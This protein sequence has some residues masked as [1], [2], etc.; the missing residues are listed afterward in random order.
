MFCD[1]LTVIIKKRDMEET[2]NAISEAFASVG[3][4]V[5]QSKTDFYGLNQ[6]RTQPFVLLGADLACT[7][8]FSQKQLQKQQ[9]YF[10][11]LDRIPMHPQLKTTLLR[12]CGAPRLR[13]ILSAM[14]PAWSSPLA[15]FFDKATIQALSKIIHVGVE[16]LQDSGLL[17]DAMGASIPQYSKL[18]GKLYEAARNFAIFDVHTPVELVTK[19]DN[20]QQPTA[21]HNLDSQWLW[22]DGT[23]S[24]AEFCTAYCIRL[25]IIQP[26][27]RVQPTRCDCGKLIQNDT[28]QLH[29]TI[30][31][32]Q[33]TSATHTRRHN[34]LRD[35]ICRICMSF[36]I[37]AVKEPTCYQ[38]EVGRKRPDIL[39]LTH[40]IL[41]TD[42]T[43]VKP[44]DEPGEAAKAADE[45]KRKQ[46]RSAVE[47]KQHVFIPGACEAYGLIGEGLVKLVKELAKDLPLSSQFVFKRT[48]MSAISTALAR[49]R[50]QGIYGT[51]HL[52][53]RI[54][55]PH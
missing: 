6:V 34:M 1:D 42:V 14:P 8:E 22:Y 24:P 5:N 7:G 18:N 44:R 50:A 12:V 15:E 45:E 2:L 10:A 51:R 38:Y 19:G 23:M 26:E 4:R 49:S 55:F 32:D 35:E 20:S 28:E 16:E 33:F 37:S 3:L 54:I 53:D 29:H 40:R 48:M 36:G 13:Y 17:H 41:V 52:Q 47:S 39:F 46:H 27:N 31:C 43:I 11:L 9:Q 21:R 25:G 30:V